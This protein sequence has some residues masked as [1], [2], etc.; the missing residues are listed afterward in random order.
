MLLGTNE[1]VTNLSSA[2]LQMSSSATLVVD[3]FSVKSS[4]LW[5]ETV[6]LTS[7]IILFVSITKE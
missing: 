2:I 5:L 7:N 3:L 4:K 1:F 6:W